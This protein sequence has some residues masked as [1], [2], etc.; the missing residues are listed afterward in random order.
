M[1]FPEQLVSLRKER[2]LRQ[3]DIACAAKI[4][5]RQY[6]RYEKGETQPTLPVLIALADFYGI[7]LDGLIGRPEHIER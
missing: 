5:T 3:E 1:A 4:T 2:G 6:Q 7:S